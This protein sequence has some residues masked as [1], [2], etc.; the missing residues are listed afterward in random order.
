MNLG[1]TNYLFWHG[2]RKMLQFELK[3][4]CSNIPHY[5]LHLSEVAGLPASVVSNARLIASAVAAEVWLLMLPKLE[6]EW[7]IVLRISQPIHGILG[8]VGDKWYK[9]LYRNIAHLNYMLSLTFSGFQLCFRRWP[10]MRMDMPSITSCTGSIVWQ[11]SF[12][13][14]DTPTWVKKNCVQSWRS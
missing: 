14:C 12:A 11:R 3:E 10:N 5:G 9:A 1:G 2:L 4:G 13:A 8:H 6:L 7:V